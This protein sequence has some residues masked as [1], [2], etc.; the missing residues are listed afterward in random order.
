MIRK[1]RR[2]LVILLLPF[3][4]LLLRL[5]ARTIRWQNRYDFEKDKG[6]IYALWHGYAL[7]LAFF[8]LDRGIVVLVS[9]FR[10]G[11]IADGLLKRFG[12]ETVRGSAE[13][14]REGKG[15][16]FA[17]LKL[18]KLLKEGKNIAITVDGPKGPP[19]KA[20]D[21]V[22]FLAQKTGAVIIPVCV[23]FEKF[24]RLNTWDRLVIPYPFTKAQFLTGKEIRVSPEDTLEE[25]RRELE[26]EL[27]RLEKMSFGN[28]G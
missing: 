9:R 17:L 27:L 25:K 26:E 20:K 18:M 1:L 13:E 19:F 8:G 7:S 22:I 24:L 16:R 21:G 5:W 2:E 14:G 23:K 28:P 10:D 15:G 4:S 6:K 3:I 12:F 11:D